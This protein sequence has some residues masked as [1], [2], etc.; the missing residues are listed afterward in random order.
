MSVIELVEKLDRLNVSR[1]K[2]CVKGGFPNEA[3]VINFNGSIWEVYYSER[4]G[5]VNEV[6]FAREDEA[7]DYLLR[8]LVE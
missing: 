3:Y 6:R 4:G 2:Y 8:I 5:K 7:C 1:D